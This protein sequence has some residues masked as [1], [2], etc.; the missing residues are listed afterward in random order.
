MV[1]SK[2]PKKQ[3]PVQS[4]CGKTISIQTR[5]FLCYSHV[6]TKYSVGQT[7]SW[8]KI[9]SRLPVMDHVGSNGGERDKAPHAHIYNINVLRKIS[10][11][12]K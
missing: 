5:G 2:K 10:Y 9:A 11:S 12:S 7:M 1:L 6:Q 4:I 3:T 8:K